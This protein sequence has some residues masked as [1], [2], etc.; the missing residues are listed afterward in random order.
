MEKNVDNK[1]KTDRKELRD[2]RRHKRI[3]WFLRHF[4]RPIVCGKFKYKAVNAKKLPEPYLVLPNHS[5]DLDPALVGMSFPHQMYFV[6]SE[7]LYRLGFA[8]KILLWAFA[9]IAKMKGASDRLMVMKVIRYLREGKNVCLFPD[10]NRSFNGKT[11]EITTAIGK[12]V[13]VSAANLVTYKITGGYFAN[14]RWGFGIRKGKMT[15][16]IVNVYTKEQL[17]AMSPEEITEAIR[18][19]VDENAYERQK[20]EHIKFVGKDRAVGMECAVCVCPKCKKVGA[21][22]TKENSVLCKTCG[23]LATYDE[24][25][26][27]VDRAEGFNFETICEWDEWQENYYSELVSTTLNTS[28]QSEVLFFSDSDIRMQTV[29]SDHQEADLGTGT[30]SLYNNKLTFKSDKTDV[31]IS[32]AELPD[33]SVYAKTGLVFSDAAGIH[34]ELKTDKIINVRKYVSVWKNLRLSVAQEE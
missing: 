23:N 30:I 9:P 27:L 12:L 5:C 11:S 13:K 3:W 28:S 1:K 21:I 31:S 7:H 4:A 32:I 14:P 6:A 16:Q 18:R 19:D 2:Y 15:G 25:G 10:G 24:Y 8:S 34:Y 29:T 26:Y 17:A 20:T 33:M 22:Q